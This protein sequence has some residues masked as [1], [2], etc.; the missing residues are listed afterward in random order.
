MKKLVPS[1]AMSGLV[2]PGAAKLNGAG[3][4]TA[5]AAD[6]RV[7][8]RPVASGQTTRK[9]ESPQATAVVRPTGPVWMTTPCGSRT[10]PDAVTRVPMSRVEVVVKPSRHVT[11][12]VPAP[13]AA[14]L[15]AVW[16]P[17]ACDAT[18]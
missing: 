8:T 10:D 14:T 17:K 2:A 5:P 15:A 16:S 12:N 7:P 11:R 6:T 18:G 4:N 13:S 3:C 1:K 9:L